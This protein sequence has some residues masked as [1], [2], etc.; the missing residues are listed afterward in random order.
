VRLLHRSSE[1]LVFQVSRREREA[2]LSLASL[3]PRIPPGH[4]KLSRSAE[5]NASNQSLLEEA[6]TEQRAENQRQ[7]RKL[8][9]DPARWIHH[10]NGWKLALR[11]S[12]AEW[13]LQVLNEIRV[14]SW[15]RLGSPEQD[16]CA[17]NEET[18]PHVWAME[19]SGALQ[20]AL[21]QALESEA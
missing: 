16:I 10:D 9:A 21:L 8:L 15:V 12:D 4:L 7:L 3:Y 6:L 18:A 14:G 1:N 13:L 11:E 17:L 5:V 2:W 19:I 20:V